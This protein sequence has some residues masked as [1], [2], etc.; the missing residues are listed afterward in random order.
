MPKQ[1]NKTIKIAENK[2]L[3]FLFTFLDFL[4]VEFIK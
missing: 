2:K 1:N 4:I 3:I